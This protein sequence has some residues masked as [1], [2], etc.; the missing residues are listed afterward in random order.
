MRTAEF[1]T[2]NNSDK[3]CD[4]VSDTLY[5]YFKSID[6]QTNC[7]LE[8]LY[9]NKSL[10]IN[11]FLKINKSILLQDIKN[12]INNNSFLKSI[13]LQEPPLPLNKLEMP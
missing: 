11:G 7:V 10:N 8:T 13:C 2:P 1:I 6:S 3:L 12:F 9:N 4:I 5:D